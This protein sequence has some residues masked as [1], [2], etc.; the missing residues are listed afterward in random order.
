MCRESEQN[1]YVYKLSVSVAML[2]TSRDEL[3][4]ADLQDRC[5]QY[6]YRFP[7]NVCMHDAHVY[8]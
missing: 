2:V 1:V 8:T 3:C 7:Y 6:V 4:H 5:A